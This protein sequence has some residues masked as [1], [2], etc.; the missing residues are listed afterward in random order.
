M[1][2]MIYEL[3]QREDIFFMT[4][5]TG[6]IVVIT[7]VKSFFRMV[8]SLAHERTR[9]EIAAYI[10]EGS[11]TPEQ[12]QRILNNKNQNNGVSGCG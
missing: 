1:E 5:I 8:S 3:M 10:A 4:M 7:V 12:G 9:R 2:T 6:G 11:M